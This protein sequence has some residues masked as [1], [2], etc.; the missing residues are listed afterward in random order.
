V[1]F[2]IFLEEKWP[3][4]SIRRLRNM[5]QIDINPEEKK[6]LEE[7]LEVAIS[8][9]GTEITHTDIHEYKEGLKKRKQNLLRCLDKLRQ[10]RS[11][12]DYSLV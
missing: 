4:K 9:L 7:I 11:S 12:G 3:A 1:F 2:G 6:L 5:S 10:S 8:D